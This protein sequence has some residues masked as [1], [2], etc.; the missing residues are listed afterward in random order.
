MSGRRRKQV[1]VKALISICI[2]AVFL[3]PFYMLLAMS[4]K[5]PI[6][7]GTKLSWP[8]HPVLENF[9]SVISSGRL[10]RAYGNT[11]L[12]AASTVIFEVFF[13]CLAAYPLARNQ[14]RFNEWIRKVNMSVMMIPTISILVGVYSMMVSIG[15][16]NTYWGVILLGTGFGLPSTIYLYT[17][18]MSSI[19]GALDEAAIMDGAGVFRTFVSVILPQLKPITTTVV[20]KKFLGAWNSF[21]YPRYLLQKREMETVQLLIRGYFDDMGNSNLNAAAACCI[22]GLLPVVVLFI[23]MNRYIIGTDLDSS[24]K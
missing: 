23:V 2:C 24:V 13:G 10:I 3:L 15:A 19:P 14:S 8:R 22:L 6:D 17:N 5:L 9:W 21:L 12:I 4:V 16:I 7:S 18:Y 20:I 11:V 1:W